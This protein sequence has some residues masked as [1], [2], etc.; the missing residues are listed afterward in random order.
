MFVGRLNII[1]R[2]QPNMKYNVTIDSKIVNQL[3]KRLYIWLHK[4]YVNCEST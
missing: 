1:K 3:I 2:E 4:S